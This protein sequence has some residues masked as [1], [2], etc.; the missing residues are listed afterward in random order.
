MRCPYLSN[1]T[2]KVCVKML[3]AQISGDLND[4][5]IKHFCDSNPIYCYYFRL[6][7]L[8]KTTENQTEPEQKISS[9]FL[10]NNEKK[11]LTAIKELL[12]KPDENP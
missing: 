1:A 9:S 7:Q 11:T 5:D 12:F 3:E 10:P 8:Q 6:P 4:F 2:K